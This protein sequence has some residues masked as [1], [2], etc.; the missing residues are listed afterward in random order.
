[1]LA[2]RTLRA[3][4]SLLKAW[5]FRFWPTPSFESEADVHALVAA[6]FQPAIIIL[7]TSV[8]RRLLMYER[9]PPKIFVGRRFSADKKPARSALLSWRFFR[10]FSDFPPMR[11]YTF[12][13]SA[14]KYPRTRRAIQ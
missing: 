13:L 6:G 8:C 12:P 1:M 10:K 14:A 9:L 3:H 5:V 7:C 4:L 2:T 11:L